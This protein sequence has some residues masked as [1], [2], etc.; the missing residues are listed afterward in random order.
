MRHIGLVACVK[1]KHARA[2]R[3]KDLYKSTL[4]TKARHHVELCCDEWFILSAKHG[5]L[6]PEQVVTPYEETL[7]N[8]GTL[9]RKQ[10]TEEVWT[11]LRNHLKPNDRVTILAGNKYREYLVELLENYGCTVNVPMAGLTIGRQLQ[12]LSKNDDKPTRA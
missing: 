10:W 11:A 2:C 8:K 5:L 7:N 12:W 4:F 1:K 9:E 3:A 6:H